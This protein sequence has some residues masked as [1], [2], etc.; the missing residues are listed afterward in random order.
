M[1][2][3]DDGGP[4]F[5]EH[6]AISPSGG[7]YGSNYFSAGMSLRDWFAGQALAGLCSQPTIHYAEV[8]RDAYQIADNALTARKEGQGGGA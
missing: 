4:A 5:P 2:K 7:I 3:V 6:V 1:S 8:V